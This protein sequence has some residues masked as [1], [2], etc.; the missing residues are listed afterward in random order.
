MED[1]INLWILCQKDLDKFESAFNL[2]KR[3]KEKY[4]L[5]VES[6]F[7]PTL[8]IISSNT[9]SFVPS[10]QHYEVA[11][12]RANRREC[13]LYLDP[14]N[15]STFHNF[16]NDIFF[17]EK[18]FDK[19][20]LEKNISYL[21]WTIRD[22]KVTFLPSKVTYK[23]F[24]IHQDFLTDFK[25]VLEN[26]TPLKMESISKQDLKTNELLHVDRAEK[27]RS[28][29]QKK[30]IEILKR[31]FQKHINGVTIFETFLENVFRHIRNS[32]DEDL[33]RFKDRN[34]NIKDGVDQRTGRRQRYGAPFIRKHAKKWFQECH[35]SKF[36][37]LTQEQPKTDLR[38]T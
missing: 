37:V 7:E 24:W 23:D 22:G 2:I 3:H 14:V 6:T 26:T 21:A 27:K 5:A 34:S 35:K 19:S 16:I 36:S 10:E 1:H 38:P 13:S 25:N 31:V 11:K 17:I 20:P 18:H 8:K 28:S 29:T 30:N 32:R 9:V 15:L 33:K 4:R 12:N